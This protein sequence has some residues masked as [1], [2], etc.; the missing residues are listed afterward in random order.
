MGDFAFLKKLADCN[1]K[2]QMARCIENH[3]PMTNADRIRAMGDEE[4]AGWMLNG[5][6]ADPCDYCPHNNYDC[7]GSCRGKADAET[8]VAWLQQPAE[9]VDHE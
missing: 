8:I 4:L 7:D 1:D 3:K 6:S 9:E 2:E 5:I